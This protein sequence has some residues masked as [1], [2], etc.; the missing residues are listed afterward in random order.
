L[1]LKAEA[2]IGEKLGAESRNVA[3]DSRCLAR[4]D[5]QIDLAGFRLLVSGRR[6]DAPDGTT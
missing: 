4:R 5:H 6:L 2:L 3:L 1:A